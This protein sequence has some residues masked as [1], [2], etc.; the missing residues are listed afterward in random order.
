VTSAAEPV[1]VAVHTAARV[2]RWTT[3]AS[4][5]GFDR[6]PGSPWLLIPPAVRAPFDAMVGAGVPLA[7]TA[8]GTPMLGV[9]CGFNTAFVVGLDPTDGGADRGD[10]S[11]VG[12]RAL[13]APA[14]REPVRRG[15]VERV[16]LRP[17]VRGATV[18]RWVHTSPVWDPGP[19][20][21]RRAIADR[22]SEWIIWTHHDPATNPSGPRPELPPHATRWLGHWR[23]QLA[24]RS[25]TRGEGPWWSLFRT[26]SAM[27]TQPRV[28]WADLGRAPRAAVLPAGD[29]TVPLNSCY[30]AR[31]PD[32]IDAQALSALL[33]SAPVAAWLNILAEP[34]R[35]NYRR[36][37]GWTVALLP[38][39]L[40]WREARALLAPIAAAAIA[41]VPPSESVLTEAVAASYGLDVDRL[42]PLLTWSGA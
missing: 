37:M 17:V 7:D 36:Y 2:Q 30:V 20:L 22:P 10:E 6:T 15:V 35:G 28:V 34:A 13:V 12:I 21:R 18:G 8:F 5:L 16:L 38:L 3:S 41:G 9:K 4:A 31:A 23:H 25:D 39:P 26:E 14:T 1:A 42:R 24:A 32:M 19:G 33:N 11:V 29:V 27:G 40:A